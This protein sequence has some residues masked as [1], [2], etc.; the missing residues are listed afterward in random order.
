[1]ATLEYYQRR[2]V[3]L[4]KELSARRGRHAKRACHGVFPNYDKEQEEELQAD[5]ISQLAT[6]TLANYSSARENPEDAKIEVDR[7]RKKGFV[8]KVSRREV[9]E[10]FSQGAISKLALIVKERP[11]GTKKRRL[12]IDLRRSGGNSKADLPEKL[13]LPRALD[14][15]ETL[16]SLHTLKSEVS[17]ED[18][19]SRW[20]REMVLVDVS[21]AFPH[22]GVHPKELE[23]C[24]APDVESTDS[25]LL[26]R[27]MLFGYKTAPLLW[28]RVAAWMARALQ[29][30]VPFEEGQHQV[31]LDDSFWCLQGTLARRN[32]LLAFILY[33]MSAVGMEV[34]A[35]KGERGD[36]VVWAGVEFRLTGNRELLITLP[37][38]FLAAVEDLLKGWTQRMAA[39][40]ELRT[41][42]GKI[43]WLSGV[44][45][46][47]KWIL[48]IFYAVLAAR[49]AEIRSGQ[50][51]HPRGEPPARRS[52]RVPRQRDRGQGLWL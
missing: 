47:A 19:R 24:L 39:L 10:H 18:Q 36:K 41:V 7:I 43:S 27:A 49:E 46:R 52:P 29:S 8:V 34:S 9:E 15:I 4:E 37:D 40:K 31:Y 45:P 51:S 50:G 26:F 35:R 12:I 32:L 14:G 23:H 25:F 42:T 30:C 16:R 21:D 3:A 20:G 28:S 5:A 6:G 33:T 38:K 44:L 22:L 48:R 13:V 1:M 11:D 17:L 2:A